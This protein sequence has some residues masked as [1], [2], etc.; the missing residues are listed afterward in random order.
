MESQK[1]RKPATKST[2]TT[3]KRRSP[4]GLGDVVES[5][6]TATGIKAAVDWFS[7]VTGVDCGCDARKE[8]L[9]KLLP[10]RPKPNCLSKQEYEELGTLFSSP[11]TKLTPEM[12]DVVVKIH[13]SVFNHKVVRPCTCSPKKW[14]QWTKELEVVYKEYQQDESKG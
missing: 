3:R 11:V 7:E 5:I 9:N 8:K 14:M 1:S 4:K 13:A 2:G 6:T 12:Q 10:L